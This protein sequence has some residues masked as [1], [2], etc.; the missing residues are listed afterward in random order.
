MTLIM[1]YAFVQWGSGLA[2]TL[3][4]DADPS[5]FVKQ[6]STPII[7]RL[8]PVIVLVMPLMMAYYIT[9]EIVNEERGK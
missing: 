5:T 4:Y 2:L 1:S 8:M 9:F 7:M 3:M 6:E